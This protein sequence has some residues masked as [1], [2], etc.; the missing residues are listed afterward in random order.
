M[1]AE[2]SVGGCHLCNV[3]H[4]R[5]I[6]C[7]RMRM[8]STCCHACERTR[9]LWSRCIALIARVSDMWRWCSLDRWLCSCERG[10]ML[11][12]TTRNIPTLFS[13]FTILC[14]LTQKYELLKNLLRCHRCHQSRHHCCCLRLHAPNPT[15]SWLVP[16]H[17]RRP[18]TRPMFGSHVL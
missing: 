7:V 17:C 16:L 12:S 14:P 18:E 6:A 9:V 8:L 11:D 15:M 10:T 5:G 2:V 3:I 4:D 13:N 1:S